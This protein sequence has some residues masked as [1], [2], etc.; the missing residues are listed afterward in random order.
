MAHQRVFTVFCVLLLWGAVLG[1]GIDDAR[2]LAEKGRFEDALVV[3][4][5]ILRRNSDDLQAHLL[6]QDVMVKA[7]RLQT[8]RAR[9]EDLAEK[10][11]GSALY[12][13][14][15]A[16]LQQQTSKRI[17]FLQRALKADEEFVP[18]RRALA[19][20]LFLARDY[21]GAIQQLNWLL[22]KDPKDAE[23]LLLFATLERERSNYDKALRLLKRAAEA[24]PESPAPLVEMGRVERERARFAEAVK[25][26]EAAS[27]RAQLPWQAILEW[28]ECL[29]GLGKRREAVAVWR[30]ALA[31]P[32][33]PQQFAVFA[34]RCAFLYV[35]PPDRALQQALRRVHETICDP[36]NV[37]AAVE[38]LALRNPDNAVVQAA[39]A[40]AALRAAQ[41]Q[42]ALKAALKAL[43]M[44]PDFAEPHFILGVYFSV[45]RDDEKALKH[46]RRAEQLNPFH[47]ETV[48]QLGFLLV[49]KG[50]PYEAAE[51][52]VRYWRLTG[53]AQGAAE[54]RLNAEMAIHDRAFLIREE[55]IGG[56]TLRI[57]RGLEPAIRG[58]HLLYRAE[59]Y[60]GQKLLRRLL[61]MLEEQVQDTPEWSQTLRRWLLIESPLK[62][63][64]LPRALR[65]FPQP[66]KPDQLFN[67]IRDVLREKER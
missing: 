9:Y 26:Y 62:P 28:G 47:P 4:R 10:H 48:R 46:L 67:I 6:Y 18:A 24:A 14:L 21:R 56:R 35:K 66:P 60:D 51:L 55:K 39:V 50:R 65:Y 44:A 7:G 2:R 53:N 27:K 3:L 32:L 52:A 20:E 17:E 5:E 61:V 15:A 19:R 58:Y 23:V 45:T 31:L 8:V 36:Q 63:N 54:L 34:E 16:R 11:P 22:K 40:T 38:E 43:K 25:H 57:W 49:R 33:T 12:Q 37:L 41:P 30:R 59:L 29:V 13:Y 1:Q 42:K 64:Q